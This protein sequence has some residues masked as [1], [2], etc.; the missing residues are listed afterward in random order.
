MH[1]GHEPEAWCRPLELCAWSLLECTGLQAAAWWCKA[2]CIS[3]ALQTWGTR[4]LAS[5]NRWQS[6]IL[7]THM[8]PGCA[9]LQTRWSALQLSKRPS[10]CP[11]QW[12]MSQASSV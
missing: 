9:D 12:L 6:S 1:H 4:W 7:A 8:V 11:L 5:E 10:P 3:C 2:P